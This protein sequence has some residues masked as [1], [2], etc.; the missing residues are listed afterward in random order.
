MYN[1][2]IGRTLSEVKNWTDQYSIRYR[3]A[4]LDG[5]DNILTEDLV[6]ARMNL[7][8]KDGIVIKVT[9]G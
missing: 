8:V 1:H 5:K 6:P 2:L 7:W 4:N 3:I 9:N